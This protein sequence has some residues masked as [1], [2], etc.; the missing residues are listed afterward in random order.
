MHE[1]FR[2][3]VLIDFADVIAAFLTGD[4][5]T[6]TFNRINDDIPIVNEYWTGIV[7]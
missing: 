6:L 1:A 4:D 2:S 3:L 5:I 7:R